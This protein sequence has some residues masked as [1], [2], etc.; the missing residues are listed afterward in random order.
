MEIQ[1]WNGIQARP[2]KSEAVDEHKRVRKRS[3]L[4]VL[5]FGMVLSGRKG[6]GC[7]S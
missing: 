1:K 6:G 5:L 4:A 3:G 2:S 7:V